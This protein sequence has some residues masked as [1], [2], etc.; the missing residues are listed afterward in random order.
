MDDELVGF[1]V[2]FIEKVVFFE[3]S[4]KKSKKSKKGVDLGQNMI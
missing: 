1:L 2:N 3:K 4:L